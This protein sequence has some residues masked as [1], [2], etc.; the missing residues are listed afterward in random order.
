M[1]MGT[2]ASGLWTH[3]L[4]CL[5]RKICVKD[6]KFQIMAGNFSGII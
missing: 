6:D 5:K 2:Q 3:P 4:G 1:I